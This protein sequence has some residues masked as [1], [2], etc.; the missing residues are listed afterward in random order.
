MKWYYAANGQQLGPVEGPDW[1][2]LVAAGT[3]RPDTLVWHEGLPNWIPYGQAVAPAAAVAPN[4][5][6][7]CG[8]TF[9][10][11][12][13]IA[14]GGRNICAGCKPLALQ[15]LREGIVVPT[16]LVY[17]GFWIRFVAKFIDGLL[18]GVVNGVLTMIS[19]MV[20]S[21]GGAEENGVLAAVV[22]VVMMLVQVA[23][24]LVYSGWFLSKYAATPGKMALGLKVIRPGG[25]PMTFGRGVGR[26]LAE[27]VS[28]ITLYIG[29][30]MAGFDQEKRS[31]HDRI[32]DTR[33]VRK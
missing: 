3:V 21:M 30:I 27:M 23:I 25:E 1:D 16:A 14:L 7:E 24:S 4:T 9:A 6:A 19:G 12:E 32:A 20:L 15:K 31:L 28:A 13:L 2:A 17:A 10:P 5:C 22:M 18:L 11:D 8:G 26:T 33:V 29:Y